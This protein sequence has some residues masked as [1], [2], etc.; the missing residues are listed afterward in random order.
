VP[1][2]LRGKPVLCLGAVAAFSTEDPFVSVGAG[3]ALR[4]PG[5]MLFGLALVRRAAQAGGVTFRFTT[6]D[7]MSV[8]DR[9]LTA[10]GL[11]L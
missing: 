8:P 1:Q 4:R 11:H 10:K 2:R 3:K 6:R 5:E 9:E 7:S